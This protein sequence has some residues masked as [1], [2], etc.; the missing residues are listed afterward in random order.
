MAFTSTQTPLARLQ[1]ILAMLDF[2]SQLLPVG[3]ETP[4]E[5]VLVALD[6]DTPDDQPS[7]YVM[8][9]FFAEDVMRAS[10]LT[11]V[12]AASSS[13]LQFMLE[14]PVDCSGLSAE[15]LLETY[16]A[17]NL[18]T[19]IMPL[20]NLGLNADKQIYFRYGHVGESQ[21][22]NA[23]LISELITMFGYFLTQFGPLLGDF[24]GSQQS[25]EALMQETGFHKAFAG[26]K[27]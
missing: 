2:V 9:I 6:Q 15:R 27:A 8:Q 23:S 5:Q 14:L 12:E 26:F 24:V 4:F 21:N 20:G 7:E 17:L 22:M 19:Q 18:F 3:T 16:S 13:T 10:G 11:E 1:E 25:V